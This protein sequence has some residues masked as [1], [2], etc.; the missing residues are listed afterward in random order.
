MN[1][2][3]L[4]TF[5]R[6]LEGLLKQL[7]PAIEDD[8]RAHEEATLPSIAVTIGAEITPDGIAWDYQTGDNSY[9]GGAYCFPDWGIVDLHRRDNSR[10]L[11]DEIVEQ[12]L[13]IWA[14][15]GTLE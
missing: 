11:A 3:H 6:D 9:I 4:A 5:R 14:Q 1:R 15:C 2:K 8:F 10:K 7:K 13:E 12:F